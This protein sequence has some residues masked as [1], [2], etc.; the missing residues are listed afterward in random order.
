[1]NGQKKRKRQGFAGQSEEDHQ[2]KEVRGNQ[3]LPV[4]DLPPEFDGVPLDGAQYLAVVRQES[5]TVPN[6]CYVANPYANVNVNS[7][8]SRQIADTDSSTSQI[9]PSLEW[10]KVFLKRFENMRVTLS[11][12]PRQMTPTSA[13]NIP[14]GRNGKKWY[15][16][17]HGRNLAQEILYDNEEEIDENGEIQEGDTHTERGE[18]KVCKCREP[19]E[20]LLH[21]FSTS[22]ILSL[23]G[24]LPYWFTQPH[25]SAADSQGQAIDPFHSR[26]LFSLLAHLDD[27]LVGDDINV[28]RIL[29]RACLACIVQ[30]RFTK[31]VG[32]Q[33]EGDTLR[34]ELGAWMIICAIAGVW[35]QHDLWEESRHD[36]EQCYQPLHS[37]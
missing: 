28:L 16:F 17:L 36:L 9:M 29:A 31:S 4:A 24:V 21:R 6:I 23:L 14:R 25:T 19:N 27:Q 2:D 30:S 22:Q 33:E 1:M 34:H 11:N 26:W 3:T 32:E 12:R 5:A 7:A 13:E 37:T 18:I 20:A 35:G 10:R 15:V 8:R